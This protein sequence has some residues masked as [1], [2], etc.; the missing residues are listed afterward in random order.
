MKY[1]SFKGKQQMKWYPLLTIDLPSASST[2]ASS[3][4]H[5]LTSLIYLHVH[6]SKQ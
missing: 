2:Y 1:S 6:D 3:A 4:A 5:K